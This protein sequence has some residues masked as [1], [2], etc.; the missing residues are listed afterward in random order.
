MPMPNYGP[1]QAYLMPA[2]STDRSFRVF[3]CVAEPPVRY[4]IVF[5]DHT[6]H[7]LLL[8]N[9]GV[10]F[11]VVKTIS[12]DETSKA[13][14]LQELPGTEGVVQHLPATRYFAVVTDDDTIR[15]T[16]QHI[17][18]SNPRFHEYKNVTPPSLALVPSAS[19]CSKSLPNPFTRWSHYHR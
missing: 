16:F 2:G 5:P 7:G 19:I 6:K 10:L 8:I 12:F 13:W 4:I 15:G 17:V 14:R 18:G 11:P 3:A 9:I 1:I